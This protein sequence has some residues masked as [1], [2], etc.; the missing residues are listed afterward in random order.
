MRAS[1]NRAAA[2]SSA[3]SLLPRCSPALLSARAPTLQLRN[4]PRFVGEPTGL[5]PNVNPSSSLRRHDTLG[6]VAGVGETSVDSYAS[7][8]FVVNGVALEGAVL[9]LPKAS[10]LFTPKR[11]ADVT[12]ASLSVLTL[13]DTPTRMLVLGCGRSSRRVPRA[14]REWCTQHDMAIEALATQH[15]CSTFNFMVAEDRPVAAVLFP[16]EVDNE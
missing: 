2:T 10:L 13:T 1:L 8:G 7:W 12:P 15:A 11:L 14:V 16:L 3:C 5:R 9:L 4:W 6:L